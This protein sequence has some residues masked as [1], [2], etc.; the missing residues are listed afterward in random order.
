MQKIPFDEKDL[1]YPMSHICSSTIY[2]TLLDLDIY[3]LFYKHYYN[4]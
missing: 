3:N 1:I 4:N 2:N